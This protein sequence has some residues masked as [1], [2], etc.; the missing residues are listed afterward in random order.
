M[1]MKT[2]NRTR[3]AF[4][5]TGALLLTGIVV[6]C[7]TNEPRAPVD[8]YVQGALAARSGDTQKAKATLTRAVND[9]PNLTM[10]RLLL[11]DLHRADADY[12]DA[13]SLYDQVTRLD[14]YGYRGFY[15]LGV[16]DQFL[17][18]FKSA[19]AAYSRAI[20]LKPDHVESATNLGTVYLTLGQSD[21]AV[22]QMQKAIEIDPKNAAAW[23]NYGIALDTMGRFPEAERAYRTSLE[24][25]SDAIATRLNLGTNLTRQNRPA[26]ALVML[27]QVVIDSDSFI[28]RKRLGDAYLLSKQYDLALVEYGKSV[29]LNGEYPP[30]LNGVA[31]T[32]IALYQAGSEI[33]ENARRQAVGA[34]KKSLS[35]NAQQQ[36]VKEQVEKWDT[37]RK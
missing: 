33:D 11:G 34:W 22:K 14:P 1:M 27:K 18:D 13:Q 26:E 35:F 32:Q 12:K 10:A 28:A 20:Q 25:D 5:W 15:S 17:N 2:L 9:D 30:A 4:V 8:R 21:D 16:T 19:A 7:Q 37:P 23:A 24:L 3:G 36:K 6:G 29:Q 31:D